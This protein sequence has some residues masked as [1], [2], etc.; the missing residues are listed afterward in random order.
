MRSNNFRAAH[1]LWALA[2]LLAL[3][4]SACGSANTTPTISVDAIYTAA[5]Q[6]LEAQQATQLAL[7]PPTST[8]SATPLPT[9][10]PTLPPVV[11]ATAAFASPTLGTGSNAC[12]SA[13]F[14]SDVT[15]PDNTNINAGK[16]FTKTWKVIN[17]GTCVW[18]TSYKLVFDS[19]DQ[20]SGATTAIT[21]PVSP[22]AVTDISV[23]MVAPNSEGTYKGTWRMQNSANQSFGSFIFVLIKVGNGATAT[24]G[25][26]PT[27]GPAGTHT[28]SGGLGA[29]GVT[30]TFDTINAVPTVTYSG[31]GSSS[32]YSFT[33]PDGWSGTITPS[34]GNAGKWTF[35]PES[36]TFTNVSSDKTNQDFT[37]NS[38][39]ATST[40]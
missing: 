3:T 36:I 25:P 22:G 35:S 29:T 26:S 38:V 14:V 10:P 17:N 20:M 28:I 23:A 33:V 31:S 18:S 24:A 7:T 40:P 39:N 37:A 30:L 4:L 8:P 15:I 6:T 5:F 16:K 2:A 19:G 32:T 12:D 9:L 11:F 34:K 1:W 13:A 21:V 27:A